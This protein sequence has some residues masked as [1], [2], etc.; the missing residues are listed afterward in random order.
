MK[1]IININLSSRL[2]PIEDTAYELLKNY[3]DSLK[4]H[5]SREEG[6]DE[7]VSDIE[8]RIAEI[9]QEKLK[10]GA[11]CITDEDVNAMVAA[12]GRPEQ[13][14][15]E[16]ATEP[17]EKQA[18]SQAAPPPLTAPVSK[19]LTRNENDKVL[20]GVCSGI[21]AYFN[22]DPVIVR[23]LT[24]LLIL[25]WGTGLLAYIILWIVLPSSR[26]L[27]NTVRKRLYRNP[28]NKVVGG[29][30][31]GIAAYLNLDPVVPR[32]I[33]VLPLLGIIFA[34]IFRHWFSF[35]GFFFPLSVGSLPTLILLYI[36]LWISVPKAKTVTEKLEMRGEKVDLQSITNAMKETQEEK[37]SDTDTTA[38]SGNTVNATGASATQGN[39]A[40]NPYNP[41]Y[42]APMHNSGL[43]DA[44]VL[45][46]KIFAY[47]ILGVIVIGLCIALVSIAGGF[48]GTAA[49]SSMMF[50]AKGLLLSSSLQKFLAWPAVFLTL[51]IPV[52]AIIWLCIK[53]IT[54]FKP[55]NRYVGSSLFILWIIGIVCMVW[56][57]ISVG[58]DFRMNY[59]ETS[60]IAIQQPEQGHLMISRMPSNVSVSGWTAFSNFI[61][62]GDDTVILK[63]VTLS[64][65]KS[66]DDSFH[67]EMVRASNGYSYERAREYAKD[68]VL[69]VSQQ[70]TVLYIPN[71]FSI[72]KGLPF[73]N[74]HVQVRVLVP[75][76]K[77]IRISDDLRGMNLR[78]HWN[79]GFS[80]GNWNMDDNDNQDWDYGGSY[81]MTK[82][83]LKDLNSNN[84]NNNNDNNDSTS[85][86]PDSSKQKPYRYHRSARNG[87]E[88]N[89]SASIDPAV[90]ALFLIV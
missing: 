18:N 16:T 60:S 46:L 73:R 9:F 19:R 78:R 56:L 6:G 23:I 24:F 77:I 62:A 41:P 29:V 49:F 74:Q 32:I 65:H 82:D 12:M 89:N 28:D 44:I 69:N 1:K 35:S 22:I 8:D 27:Q 54:G 88:S 51:G 63:T 70:D 25:A 7:I 3:L 17:Q 53:L 50:P 39:L 20:G 59:R 38:T 80:N 15:E 66:P 75:I 40:S 68:I 2:I 43:G 79:F 81:I 85:V 67:V 10:K 52:V 72:P 55:K 36:I 45:I 11:H 61:E 90:K 83:G 42:A 5:F 47:F 64:V 4:R 86:S 71:G 57:F 37:K 21:A 34:S 13:L 58:N 48:I 31:S 87:N 30:A 33:F 14:E 84:D 26:S 76:G